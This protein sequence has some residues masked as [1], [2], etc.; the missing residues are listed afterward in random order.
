[1]EEDLNHSLKLF[2]QFFKHNVSHSLK[3]WAWPPEGIQDK[4]NKVATSPMPVL[5]PL[6]LSPCSRRLQLPGRCSTINGQVKGNLNN[7]EVEKE[8]L[9]RDS[10]RREKFGPSFGL[11]A[12]PTKILDDRI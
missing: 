3:N 7:S 5:A 11:V 1:M 9:L 2:L 10:P 8:S 12:V 6:A 4:G